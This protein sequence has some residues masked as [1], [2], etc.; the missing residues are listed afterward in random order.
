V[1]AS[2]TLGLAAIALSAVFGGCRQVQDSLLYYPTAA[3]RAPPAP[4]QGWSA[5]LITLARPGGIEL[6]GWLVKPAGPPAPLL[7]YFG[8]NAEEVSWLIA[9]A[10]RVGRRAVALV[11]Y[12]GY[13][14]SSG[15]PAEAALKDDGLALY[16]ALVA[17]SDV[18]GTAVAVMGR[19]LG[20]GIA[21]H[22]AAQ[23]P[24]D[25]VVLISPYDSI[26]AVA[27]HHFPAALVRAV[28]LDRYDTAAL[29]PSIR[30]PMIAIAA[31]RDDVIPVEYSRRLHALW[32][33]P[34]Q[35]LELPRAGHN[36]LQEYPEYWRSIEAFLAK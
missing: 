16:D 24:V 3:P 19:S 4:P 1:T 26:A 9:T 27:A 31:S 36:D 13:G 14:T 5:D 35:W 10:N 12:R 11:N 15:K 32:G 28:L 17:R 18:D 22:V 25:R 21:V 29:A 33:G 34:K 30:A 6:R 20:T 2:R 7:L 8:G 23:R